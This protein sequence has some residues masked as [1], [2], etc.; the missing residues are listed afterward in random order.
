M[1]FTAI[2]HPAKNLIFAIHPLITGRWGTFINVPCTTW[3]EIV[4]GHIPATYKDETQEKL[5]QK[6][7]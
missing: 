4:I 3:V 6:E 7:L 2:T 5:V 1:V